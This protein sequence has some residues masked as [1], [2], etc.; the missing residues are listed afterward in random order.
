MTHRRHS[1]PS[2]KCL[3]FFLRTCEN[4]SEEIGEYKR[5][6]KT[7]PAPKKVTISSSEIKHSCWKPYQTIL[8]TNWQH[9]RIYKGFWHL[10]SL[11]I[12]SRNSYVGFFILTLQLRRLS[13]REDFL[14]AQI[15]RFGSWARSWTQ[16]FRLQILCPFCYL[17]S[18]EWSLYFGI[19]LCLCYL[20]IETQDSRATV[21]CHTRQPNL[22]GELWIFVLIYEG[23]MKFMEIVELKWGMFCFGRSESK[24][25][26]EDLIWVKLFK[27]TIQGNWVQLWEQEAHFYFIPIFILLPDLVYF[28]CILF[29]IQWPHS[30]YTQICRNSCYLCSG[31]FYFPHPVQQTQGKPIA[32]IYKLLL[33]QVFP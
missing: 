30:W 1:N 25:S 2:F 15:D 7:V 32:V 28:Y 16:I 31:A 11:F 33:W 18:C 6:E 24:F 3:V 17:S 4:T 12:L 13:L 26:G 19:P 10:L 29:W 22:Y 9:V 21:T 23:W 8:V 5:H 20:N 14:F 27:I